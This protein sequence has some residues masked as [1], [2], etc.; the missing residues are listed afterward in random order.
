VWS[1]IPVLRDWID[2]SVPTGGGVDTV[3]RGST[4]IRDDAHPY[5]QR[6]GAG[7]KEEKQAT[8]RTRHTGTSC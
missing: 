7:S 2:I 8:L 6:F 3:N 4:T 5:E 1:R